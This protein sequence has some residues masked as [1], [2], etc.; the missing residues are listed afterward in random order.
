MTQLDVV[1]V[2]LELPPNT[3]FFHKA[4]I[5]LRVHLMTTM[6]ERIVKEESIHNAFNLA[7]DA[8][9]DLYTP[10]IYKGE[11][12]KD[13]YQ[14]KVCCICDCFISVADLRRKIFKMTSQ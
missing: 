2:F 4:T 7:K 11:V 3:N 10:V 14:P 12:V 1:L 8:M 13:T 9:D 6:M 5:L